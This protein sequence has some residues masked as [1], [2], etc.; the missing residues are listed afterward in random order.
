[1]SLTREERAE[2]DYITQELKGDL[3]TAYL[4]VRMMRV[5]RQAAQRSPL[6]V[7]AAEFAKLGATIAAAVLAAIG[8]TNTGTI[9]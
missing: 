9:R 6:K 1:M 4:A 7:G 8:A 2:A 5:E 3:A